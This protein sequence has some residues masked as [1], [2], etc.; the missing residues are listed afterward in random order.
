M[1]SGGFSVQCSHGFEVLDFGIAV[2]LREFFNL[3]FGANLL[4]DPM[5]HT[6]EIPGDRLSAQAGE[7][8]NVEL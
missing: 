2:I 4:L 3:S 7:P 6:M 5:C 1:K 8:P